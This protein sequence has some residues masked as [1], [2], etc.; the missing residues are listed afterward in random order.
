MFRVRSC[1]LAKLQLWGTPG[2]S[3]TLNYEVTI[4]DKYNDAVTLK[5]YVGGAVNQTVSADSRRILSCVSFRSFWIS[6][7]NG[8]ILVGR[9]TVGEQVLLDW[10]DPAPRPVNALSLSSNDTKGITE[11]EY[12]KKGGRFKVVCILGLLS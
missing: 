3:S 10:T 6:W 5:R 2:D 7:A 1:S 9:Y 4:G 12:D 8:K 11:W